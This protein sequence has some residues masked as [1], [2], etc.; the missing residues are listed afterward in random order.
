MTSPRRYLSRMVAF[1]LVVI[2]LAGGLFTSAPVLADAFGANRGLNGLILGMLVVGVFFTIRQVQR[3]GPEVQWIESYRRAETGMSVR[4]SPVLLAPMAM[5][6]RERSGGRASLSTMS[7][8]SILDSISSRLDESRETSRYLTGLL[9]FLGLLG[10]FWG[11]L[12]T[13]GSVSGV[14][15][16]LSGTSDTAGLFGDLID[17]LQAPMAGMGTAFSSSLFGLSGALV[18]GFLDLQTGQAQN[19]FYNDLEEWLSSI[20]RL[21]SGLGATGGDQSIPAYVTALLEQTAESLDSLQ[22]TISRG[23]EDRTSANSALLSLADRLAT[24]TDQMR[25][26][27]GLMVKLLESQMEIKPVLKQLGDSLSRDQTMTLDDASRTHLRNLDV[28]VTRLS[29]DASSGRDQIIDELR[30]EFKLLARTLASLNIDGRK[31]G[32]E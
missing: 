22:R 13:I 26:E 25:T 10:T 12:E 14:I 2:V 1:V 3:L 32:R 23:E 28:Y 8:T 4:R 16:G 27:Q 30:R 15:E 9:I 24:L 11:L 5:M 18:L 21:S 31:S 29:K 7:M 20:T 19:R 17:G 6:L